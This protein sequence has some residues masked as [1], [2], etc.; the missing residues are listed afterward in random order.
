MNL[1]VLFKKYKQKGNLVYEYN[2]IRNLRFDEDMYYY[3]NGLYSKEELEKNFG[4]EISGSEFLLNKSLM[5]EDIPV[6][7]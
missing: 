2:P 4:I 5:T 1:Q 3:H 6:L 7:Y